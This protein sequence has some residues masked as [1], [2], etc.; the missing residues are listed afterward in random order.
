MGMSKISLHIV[1]YSYKRSMHN[2]SMMMNNNHWKSIHRLA[3]E[4]KFEKSLI[5]SRARNANKKIIERIYSQ[6][7]INY[8]YLSIILAIYE[9]FSM[10][11][12]N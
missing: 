5:Y 1:L 8:Y 2:I 9:S 10:F 3:I 12:I 11:L 6:V 4:S 7:V